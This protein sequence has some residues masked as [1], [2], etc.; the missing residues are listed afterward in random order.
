MAPNSPAFSF[1][2]PAPLRAGT[3]TFLMFVVCVIIPFVI[4]GCWR[5]AHP[6][7]CK[8][9]A[10]SN[11]CGSNRQISFSA[12]LERHTAIWRISRYNDEYIVP[13]CGRELSGEGYL[14][15]GNMFTGLRTIK[16]IF[17]Q[18]FCI[19]K[20]TFRLLLARC[21][22]GSV[23]VARDEWRAIRHK[24]KPLSHRRRTAH[25]AQG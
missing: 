3:S 5:S 10:R 2:V 17:R 19:I 8:T 22:H 1:D 20:E 23:A 12:S 24:T 6:L 11:P 9:E 25:L 21:G 18:A 14:W 7:R 15:S 4:I 13:R 16:L